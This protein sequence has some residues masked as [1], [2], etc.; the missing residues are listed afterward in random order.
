MKE[1]PNHSN[2][3]RPSGEETM[4]AEDAMQPNPGT[5]HD[6]GRNWP[7]AHGNLEALMLK[8][9]ALISK[10]KA[11]KRAPY[12]DQVPKM[13]EYR[14]TQAELHHVET[15]MG[16]PQQ[17]IKMA[18]QGVRDSMAAS[19]YVDPSYQPEYFKNKQAYE[20]A[21][22]AGKTVPTGLY[23]QYVM[24]GGHS[25]EQT[26]DWA[27]VNT[28]L[29]GQEKAN[30]QREAIKQHGRLE[31]RARYQYE[32]EGA[33]R[34]A[35]NPPFI[36]NTDHKEQ[37][38]PAAPLD[39]KANYIKP[40]SVTFT[41]RPGNLNRALLTGYDIVG[42]KGK[43]GEFNLHTEAPHGVNQMMK[44]VRNL[45]AGT[46]YEFK[47]RA[48][49]VPLAIRRMSIQQLQQQLQLRGHGSLE[50]YQQMDKVKLM[51]RVAKLVGVSKGPF[52]SIIAV[53]TKSDA[54]SQV[55]NVV[56]SSMA[57]MA[58]GAKCECQL[59]WK[60]PSANGSP[61]T[62]YRILQTKGGDQWGWQAVVHNTGSSATSHTITGLEADGYEY[63][64][65]VAAIN[66]EGRGGD[67]KQS[68]GVETMHAKAPA[69][70]QQPKQQ[71]MA[72]KDSRCEF[73]LD[74]NEPSGRGAEIHG[75]KIVQ[76]INNLGSFKPRVEDTENLDTQ[77][78]LRKL[79]GGTRYEFKVAGINKE[80][81]GDFSNTLDFKTPN[82]VPDAPKKPVWGDIKATSVT[83]T[84]NTPRSNGA[85]ITGYRVLFQQGGTG[86]FFEKIANTGSAD[87]S[88]VVT[89]LKPGGYSYQF[90]VQAINSVGLGKP[91]PFSD[92]CSTEYYEHLADKKAV[93]A[94]T[95]SFD[96]NHKLNEKKILSAA[97]KVSQGRVKDLQQ[98][99]RESQE[100]SQKA[101]DEVQ[102][103][104]RLLN[105]QK[106]LSAKRLTSE[107][108]LTAK[109]TVIESSA[110]DRMARIQQKL[111]DRRSQDAR[112]VASAQLATERK[113]FK[114]IAKEKD[115]EIESLRDE[116]S[117]VHTKLTVAKMKIQQLSDEPQEP[118]RVELK[119]NREESDATSA[120]PLLLANPSKFLIPSK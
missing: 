40:H 34:P 46:D 94:A 45:D 61:I 73:N 36:D 71:N 37:D 70:P 11:I 89:G 6:G 7:R 79:M 74:W 54:P 31:N 119:E 104:Q 24:G 120:T 81:I 30:A 27:D 84:W 8:R 26:T 103:L 28:R 115:L 111:A 101:Q 21:V 82:Q 85:Q 67:S 57:Y 108:D 114:K 118:S 16:M 83:L 88:V 72:C 52:S 60:A 12:E 93:A 9:E 68:V 75:Y 106:L 39:M 41:W 3:I 86:G 98:S 43:S 55:T 92:A 69:A 78:T 1:D 66:A 14:A 112:D 99:Y 116:L 20:D 15:Q 102:Q 4:T 17:T 63:A 29:R 48:V 117:S 44:K 105:S 53:T 113:E 59:N 47:I 110:N 62:G 2:V 49:Y 64:F 42:R 50:E 38:I 19:N 13:Q 18:K 90:E 65:K 80:G 87:P 58:T 51:T 32:A 100:R 35:S 95:I 107:R 56:A 5:G 96:V 10:M 23:K 25:S 76:R 33:A 97:L 77:S 22:K 91:S 109:Q